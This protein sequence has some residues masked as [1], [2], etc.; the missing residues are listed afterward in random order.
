MA[1][2]QENGKIYLYN[3]SSSGTPS[4]DVGALKQEVKFPQDGE[5]FEVSAGEGATHIM[6]RQ[7]NQ[8]VNLS[9]GFQY[10]NDWQGKTI[11]WW[12]NKYNAEQ[13]RPKIQAAGGQISPLFSQ[14]NNNGS[15][16]NTYSD[17]QEIAQ[18]A[19]IQWNQPGTPEQAVSYKP[20][21][22]SLNLP[23][24]SQIDTLHNTPPP[25]G[26][27]VSMSGMQQTQI[28]FKP[29]L[30]E[31]QKASISQLAQKPQDQWNQNDIANWNYATNNS[32]RPQAGT[33][34]QSG[35]YVYGQQFLGSKANDAA[36]NQLY[37]SYFGRNATQDE[38]NNWGS[39]GGADTTVQ[40]LENFLQQERQRYG[41]TTPVTGIDGQPVTPPGGD[42]AGSVPPSFESTGDTG[43]DQLLGTLQT[44][45]DELKKRG[46][47]LNPD[48]T[49]S[50]EKAA[51]FLRQAE[52]EINPYYAEQLKFART[53]L[54]KDAG[55]AQEQIVNF[56]NQMSQ[57][58]GEA[59]RQT[60]ESAADR[61][62][63][64]SGIRK[65]EE[66]SLATDVQQ[67]LD[68]NRRD[69][70]FKL[71]NQAENYIKEF[72]SSSMPSLNMSRAPRVTGLGGF[73]SGGSE[74]PFFQISPELQNGIIG[75]KE[76][77][78][79]GQ[80][81]GRASELESAY[82]TQQQIDQARKLIL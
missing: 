39:R 21:S 13:V 4:G 75:S 48:V 25:Q 22:G 42:T 26:S 80:V 58:Y 29:G 10:P 15:G 8:I 35:Q 5:Y 41:V 69:L 44:Y 71:G 34:T 3:P 32:P 49:I 28:N 66:T 27:P 78:R 61:G 18:A 31:A 81:S 6:Q 54:L 9:S 11:G 50:P 60:A 1:Y 43:L 65:R 12:L 23:G 67:M 59:Y 33:Q 24:Q 63:A 51:E 36:V 7:G 40:A 68:Q 57:K 82:R 30:S 17:L 70:Q 38:L 55:Y 77:E 74:S 72:G 20:T 62:F 16:T 52:N 19:G 79:R 64:Q 14:S 73:E 46:L 53:G 37:N 76:F 47:V 56:E 45:L 2:I